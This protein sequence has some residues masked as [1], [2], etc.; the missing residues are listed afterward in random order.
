MATISY[1]PWDC[2]EAEGYQ[3]QYI[4]ETDDF[5]ELNLSDEVVKK[6]D[7]RLARYFE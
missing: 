6:I 7:C 3:E 2:H 5:H 4:G 1:F